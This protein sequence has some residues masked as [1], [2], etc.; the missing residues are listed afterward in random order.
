[1]WKGSGE[2]EHLSLFIDKREE[3]MEGAQNNES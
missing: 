2:C 1:M 3:A